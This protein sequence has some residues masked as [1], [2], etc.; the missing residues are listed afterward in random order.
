VAVKRP[1]GY[2]SLF[3]AVVVAD[4]ANVLQDAWTVSAA[5]QG[6]ST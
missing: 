6:V 1:V 4:A 5:N 2:G 3:V